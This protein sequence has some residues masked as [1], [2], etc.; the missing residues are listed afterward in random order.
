MQKLNRET[1]AIDH[2]A[3]IYDRMLNGRSEALTDGR[4]YTVSSTE[5]PGSD[6]FEATRRRL[7]PRA[8]KKVAVIGGGSVGSEIATTLI[9]SNIFVVLKEVNSEYL[10]K[11][12]KT[13]EANIRG[14]FARKKLAQS[15]AEKALTMIEGVLPY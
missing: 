7:K 15:R 12:I 1:P 6:P 4:G 11:R 8:V 13:V 14:M 10:L 3:S 5:L 9:I 2:V